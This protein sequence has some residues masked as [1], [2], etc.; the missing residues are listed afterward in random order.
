[1][2][3][4][5]SFVLAMI[6]AMMK[7]RLIIGLAI[8][9]GSLPGSVSVA[10]TRTAPGAVTARV[11]DRLVFRNREWIDY[12]A[13]GRS[14]PLQE[15]ISW[16]TQADFLRGKNGRQFTFICP[17]NGTASGRLWGSGFYTD[18]SSIC[19]AGVHAGVITL[20]NGGLVTIEIRPGLEGY[21][22]SS[23]NGITSL[24]Y[25]FWPGSFVVIRDAYS[26]PDRRSIARLLSPARRL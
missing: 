24:S 1:M 23:R 10:E 6:A 20:R 19:T 11:S 25:D 9:L 8:L 18:D 12:L 3:P 5:N 22:S 26:G 2:T 4:A 14:T 21:A 16:S 17:P 7:S 13:P 15:T